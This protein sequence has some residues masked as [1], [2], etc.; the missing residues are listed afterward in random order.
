[1]LFLR[2]LF[3]LFNFFRFTTALEVN[4]LEPAGGIW[5]GSCVL[6]LRFLS[7][8]GALL[9]TGEILCVA[10]FFVW[11][12]LVW[13]EP[14]FLNKGT[15]AGQGAPRGAGPPRARQYCL[16]QLD[17]AQRRAVCGR[18]GRCVKMWGGF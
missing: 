13:S 15:S 14:K 6:P 12:V 8:G 16:G 5:A 11:G 7:R 18:M 10:E 1:M 4:R 2:P 3:A 17:S 9:G